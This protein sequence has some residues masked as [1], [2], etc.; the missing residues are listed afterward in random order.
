ML[1]LLLPGMAA[2]SS[3][4]GCALPSSK[5]HSGV[6]AAPRTVLRLQEEAGQRAY[7]PGV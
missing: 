3:G 2:A 6:S 1:L 7:G 4:K 5:K